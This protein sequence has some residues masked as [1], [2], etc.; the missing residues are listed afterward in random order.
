MPPAVDQQH[1]RIP[2]HCRSGGLNFPPQNVATFSAPQTVTL[3]N[4]LATA[5]TIRSI[6]FT[7]PAAADFS[8]P[9]RTCGASLAPYARCFIEVRFKPTATGTRMAELNVQDGASHRPQTVGL[10]GTGR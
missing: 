6:N 8:S 7:G 5:L 4:R 10:T 3:T 9:D 2:V 1:R